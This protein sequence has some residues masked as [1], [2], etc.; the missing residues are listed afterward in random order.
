MLRAFSFIMKDTFRDIIIRIASLHNPV[1]QIDV[2]AI[3]KE[4]LVQQSHF[5]QRFTAEKHESA[6]QHLDLMLL[7]LIQIRQAVT[8]KQA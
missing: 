8:G 2:F 5:I 6:S 4:R 7:L 3:H 1:G